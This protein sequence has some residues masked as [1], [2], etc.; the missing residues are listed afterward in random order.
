MG[1]NFENRCATVKPADP[2][3]PVN[4]A[5]LLR[6]AMKGMGTDEETIITVL[7]KRSNPQ[8][9]EIADQFKT[10]YGKDLIDDLKS[11]LGG[12]LEDMILALMTPAAE[13]YAK[14]LHKA[15]SGMGTDEE[16]LVEIL[17]TMTNHDIKIIAE[18]YQN[19]YD[20]S[21][22]DDLKGDTDGTFR[23]LMVSLCNAN[24]EEGFDV[25]FN[26]AKE[27][28][29]KLLEAGDG[30]G[31]DE[32]TFNMI[33]CQRNYAQLQ[34]IFE[35]YQAIS[36]NDI[37][38]AIKSEFAGNAEDAYLAVVRAAK[39]PAAYFA[40]RLHHC[41][42][43]MGTEDRHLIRLIVA[44]CEVDME[45]IKKEYAAMYDQTLGDA[46]RGDCPGEYKKIL[47]ALC[48]EDFS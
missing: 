23:R 39:N 42:S 43:G 7:A 20:N 27:D 3:E 5:E 33:L 38:D 8:R 17:C 15:I 47:L 14:E 40:K 35:D 48:G 46:I 26:A 16:V 37:E 45:D 13:Y 25:D 34:R 12:N 6:G 28:A 19:L 41:M 9:Q 24:R 18:T 21:L 32:S 22:E 1:Y 11:E 2:F 29:Q 30:F 10:M 4:D 31:T 44:R 36:G